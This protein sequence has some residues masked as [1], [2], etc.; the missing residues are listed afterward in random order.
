MFNFNLH[1]SRLILKKAE[2]LNDND[3]VKDEFDIYKTEKNK[4]TTLNALC[5]ILCFDFMK[6]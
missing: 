3:L 4:L 5:L 1:H 2:L 6:N